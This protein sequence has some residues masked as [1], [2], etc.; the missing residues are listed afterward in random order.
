MSTTTTKS[1]PKIALIGAG[2]ASLT[3][4]SLLKCHDIPFTIYEAASS[5]RH[6]GGTL[7]LHPTT[8]QAAL[9]EAGLWDAF[10]KH[11]RPESDVMKLVDIGGEVCWDENGADKQEVGESEEEKFAG[12]PEID[13]AALMKILVE[14]LEEGSIKFGKKLNEVVPSKTEEKKFNLVFADGKEEGFDLVIGGDGAWSK[15]RNLLSDTKPHYSGISLI[16]VW[17]NDVKSNPWLRNYVGN[18]SCFSF[19]E[20]CAILSQRQGDG[21]QRTYAC[22]RVPEDFIETCSIDWND[23]DAARKEFMERHFSHAGKDLKR[24]VMESTDYLIPRTLYE[25]PVGFTWESRPGV[26][27]I[28]DS[29]HLMTPFAGVGVNVGMTDSLVLAHEIV[30]ACKGKKSLDEAL[31][32]YEKEM[33]PRAARYAQKTAKNKKGHFTEGGSKH[34]A[35]RIRAHYEEARKEPNVQVDRA[36]GV[37]S[38]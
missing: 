27:L 35:D 3:L 6:A 19:G 10:V 25:L 5:L 38:G 24:V 26:T 15:V 9:K 20:G 1:T 12:R 2:P 14:S 32:A 31:Q 33:F 36:E 37:S 23:K 8:G 7:D 28:G 29:A 30:A 18:G 17:C 34:M 21:S 11:A 16:E 4:A 22:L 13:R